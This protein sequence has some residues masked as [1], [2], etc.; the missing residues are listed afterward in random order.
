MKSSTAPLAAALL[1]I[2]VLL[3][4]CT[5][6]TGYYDV[7]G[8]VTHNGQPVP[9]VF[10]TFHPANTDVHP[11]AMAM[12]DEE[13]RFELAVGS[14]PGVPPGE[15]TVWAM[16]PA[17]LN[18]GATSDAPEYKAVITKYAPGASTYKVTIDQD[19]TDLELK[20]D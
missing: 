2:P 13:G 8:V 11:E 17:A 18:G 4:G 7:A 15:H 16:D 5:P 6:D 19:E 12:T 3:T 1:L 14:T 9:K 20:L 10:I